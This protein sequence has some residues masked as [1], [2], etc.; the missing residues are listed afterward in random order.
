V[1][2]E[3]VTIPILVMVPS[4]LQTQA[5]EAVVLDTPEVYQVQVVPES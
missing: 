5:V 3:M 2:V 1:V 4:A